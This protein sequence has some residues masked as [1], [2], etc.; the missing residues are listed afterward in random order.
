LDNEP[1]FFLAHLAGAAAGAAA[2]RLD[3]T[4]TIIITYLVGQVKGW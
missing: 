3:M 2:G 1:V 4:M